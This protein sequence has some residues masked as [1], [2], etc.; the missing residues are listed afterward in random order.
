MGYK[1]TIV[2]GELFLFQTTVAG[3]QEMQRYQH[4]QADNTN[5]QKTKGVHSKARDALR[6]KL[7]NRKAVNAKD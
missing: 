1:Y 3:H 7:E 5:R 2:N 6:D 4:T